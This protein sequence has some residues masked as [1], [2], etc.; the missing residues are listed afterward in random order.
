MLR[1][2]PDLFRSCPCFRVFRLSFAYD[3]FNL[4]LVKFHKVEIFIVKRV[5][6]G[7]NKAWVGIE[8]LT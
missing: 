6:Q 7:R 1:T 2:N 5:I 4:L 8:P 3:F